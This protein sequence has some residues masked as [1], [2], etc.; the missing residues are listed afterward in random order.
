MLPLCA[1]ALPSPIPAGGEICSPGGGRQT[2]P[3]TGDPSCLSATTRRH[4]TPGAVQCC[5][6][7]L[8]LWHAHSS[9]AT[10]GVM[11]LSWK[12]VSLVGSISVQWRH[13]G[14]G[15]GAYAAVLSSY[16]GY[17]AKDMDLNS[18]PSLDDSVQASFGGGVSLDDVE[19]LQVS[20]C[21]FL[22]CSC[23]ATAGN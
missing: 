13:G 20:S 22:S 3:E 11:V 2:G 19:L 9:T 12:V 5:C 10:A 16:P 7:W 15:G 14:G 8:G 6:A 1:P 4:H 17:C 21:D 23:P 18:I